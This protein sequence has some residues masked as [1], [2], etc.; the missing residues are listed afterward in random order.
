MTSEEVLRDA[1]RMM[2]DA[3]ECRHRAALFARCDCGVLASGDVSYAQDLA[4][5]VQRP[6][7][8]RKRP[9][10]G[11]NASRKTPSAEQA[12]SS[13]TA[14]LQRHFSFPEVSPKNS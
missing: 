5:G 14:I 9:L 11:K 6:L 1:V 8:G 13:Y 2:A 4:E 10:F 3:E 7:Y 12:R